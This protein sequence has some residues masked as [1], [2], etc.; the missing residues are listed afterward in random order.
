LV[1]QKTYRLQ[2]SNLSLG[3]FA[4]RLQSAVELALAARFPDSDRRSSEM[5]P[6]ELAH[7]FGKKSRS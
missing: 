4:G 1:F 3:A 7:R 5:S 2:G 6:E